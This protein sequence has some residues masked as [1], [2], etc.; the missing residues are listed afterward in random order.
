MKKYKQ[1]MGSGCLA[2]L[3]GCQVGSASIIGEVNTYVESSNECHQAHEQIESLLIQEQ[4]LYDT[5]VQNGVDSSVFKVSEAF[6]IM[7]PLTETVTSYQVCIETLQPE[8][9]KL[10]TLEEADT[11]TEVEQGVMEQLT[12]YHNSTQTL[13]SKLSEVVQTQYQFYEAFEANA[14]IKTL[15]SQIQTI[16]TQRNE[17]N[18]LRLTQDEQLTHFNEAYDELGTND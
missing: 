17:L 11:L 14:E 2:L 18:E 7:Q 15:E 8:L 9:E 6:E 13:L 10:T 3:S 16:N 5:L 12:Q 1:L 4:G